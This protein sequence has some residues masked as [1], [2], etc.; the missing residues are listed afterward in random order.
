MV[1]SG[2][3]TA[4]SALNPMATR[5]KPR[6]S[7]RVAARAINTP[8]RFGTQTA[9]AEASVVNLSSSF[10]EETSGGL[11]R[12]EEKSALFEVTILEN[13]G[14]RYTT[15]S[16]LKYCASRVEWRISQAAER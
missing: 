11:A 4:S 16:I 12:E 8:L 9:F 6:L 2:K 10:S 15:C 1:L 5:S 13:S 3:V 7:A 14:I